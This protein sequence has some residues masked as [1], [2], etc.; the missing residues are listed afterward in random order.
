M[1]T[2]QHVALS[3]GGK[4]CPLFHLSFLLNFTSQYLREIV[5]PLLQ[6]TVRI[7]VEGTE[8]ALI[9]WASVR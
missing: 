2:V 5:V 9:R 3:P 7:E 6:C 1:P 8:T 4:L